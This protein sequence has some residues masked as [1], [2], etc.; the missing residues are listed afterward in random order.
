MPF[1]G[2]TKEHHFQHYIS[3]SVTMLIPTTDKLVIHQLD[4]DQRGALCAGCPMP[5]CANPVI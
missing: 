2:P 5:K 3:L 4:L 1:S